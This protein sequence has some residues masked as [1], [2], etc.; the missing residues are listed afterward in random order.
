VREFWQAAAARDSSRIARLSRSPDPAEW[1]LA[2]PDVREF[3]GATKDGTVVRTGYYEAADTAYVQVEVPWITCRAPAYPG[4][5][6]RYSV[7]LARTP[8]GWLI[9]NIWLDIC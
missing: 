3:F 1:A 6:D 2:V 4:N 7:R 5:K 9:Q 8:Q